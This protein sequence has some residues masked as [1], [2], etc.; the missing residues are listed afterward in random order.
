MDRTDLDYY[1][2]RMAAELV[3]AERASHPLAA[4]SH[5][6]LADE[7]AMLIEANGFRSAA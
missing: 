5:R 3:A 2:T 4:E 7:Y 1:R 6:R